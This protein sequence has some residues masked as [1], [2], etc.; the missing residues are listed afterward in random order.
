VRLLGPT[1][2]AVGGI[3]QIYEIATNN[4]QGAPSVANETN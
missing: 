1:R 3:G 2:L 4:D